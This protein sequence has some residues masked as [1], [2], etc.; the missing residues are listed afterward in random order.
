MRS[1]IAPLV[2]SLFL[3]IL[4]VTPVQASSRASAP[5]ASP[6]EIH[7]YLKEMRKETRGLSPATPE[8]SMWDPSKVSCFDPMRDS[9]RRHPLQR[10]P[11]RGRQVPG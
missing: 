11:H 2:G 8:W 9:L 6:S 7:W 3:L 1:A 5:T 4:P 10:M